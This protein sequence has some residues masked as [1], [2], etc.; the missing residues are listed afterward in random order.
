MTSETILDALDLI[1]SISAR[2]AKEEKLADII[3]IRGAKEVFTFALDRYISFGVT[4]PDMKGSGNYSFDLKDPKDEVRTLLMDMQNRKYTPAEAV[5]ALQAQ[6]KRL[7]PKSAELLRRIVDKDL[8]CGVGAKTVNKVYPGLIPTFNVMLAHPAD[9]D[10]IKSWPQIVEPKIDGYRTVCMVDDDAK[11]LSRV[12][13]EYTGVNSLAALVKETVDEMVKKIYEMMPV[14]PKET[15]TSSPLMK[16]ILPYAN[17]D[18]LE[19]WVIDGELMGIDFSDTGSVRSGNESDAVFYIFDIMPMARFKDETAYRVDYQKR[20][21][22]L[23]FFHSCKTSDRIVKVPRYI[24]S[25]VEEIP[26]YYAKF[27]KNGYEGLMIKDPNG[28]YTKNRS[29]DWMKMKEKLT[30][31]FRVVALKEGTKKNKG[32]LGAFVVDVNG[33]NVDVGSGL[34]DAERELYWTNS[35]IGRLIE[36]EFQEYT[37]DGSLRHPRFV[38]LRDDKDDSLLENSTS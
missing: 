30:E 29:Y 35:M 7:N 21:M 9:L 18:D 36:V 33:V 4:A 38:R 16:A 24:V 28:L 14:S 19:S 32:K 5:V 22:W 13:F 26:V 23:D 25:K 15:A 6:E 17:P 27:R 3:E 31:E 11:F 8:R 12:G 2:T 20:R 37:D 1:A 34:S 10:R